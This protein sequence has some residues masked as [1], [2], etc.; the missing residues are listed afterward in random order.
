[1]LKSWS[2]EPI[3]THQNKQI[4]RLKLNLKK[5]TYLDSNNRSNEFYKNLE[6][7]SSYIE[8]IYDSTVESRC[9][10]IA[11]TVFIGI[12][13][14]YFYQRYWTGKSLTGWE[15]KEIYQTNAPAIDLSNL[16]VDQ[17]TRNTRQPIYLFKA[18]EVQ[19]K[20]WIDAKI[21]ILT[22]INQSH[23]TA[24]TISA[25]SEP[26]GKISVSQSIERDSRKTFHLVLKKLGLVKSKE[27]PQ[28]YIGSLRNLVNSST[29]ETFVKYHGVGTALIQA[30][31]QH[32]KEYQ[33][34]ARL[35]STNSSWGFYYRLGF[36][37]SDK[38][39]N[40]KIAQAIQE[41]CNRTSR[42]EEKFNYLR[43]GGELSVPN[44]AQKKW[45]TLLNE[46]PL[47]ILNGLSPSI[48]ES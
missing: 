44:W 4:K 10:G 32:F 20:R 3:T 11:L 26:L 36:R 12:S 23:F 9:I 46:R 41:G 8:T 13:L 21:E 33:C 28:L 2:T 17:L 45:C 47:P 35:C 1:M 14:P 16:K 15:K 39:K 31:F 27:K 42:S 5:M 38:Q 22:R 40:S 43:L 29:N 37:S 25:P 18:Y 19:T 30:V 48:R 6:Y 7:F 24:S 34:N